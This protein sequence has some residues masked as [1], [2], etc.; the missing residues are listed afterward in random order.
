MSEVSIHTL[1]QALDINYEEE[2]INIRAEIV[3]MQIAFYRSEK[4]FVMLD[5][6]IRPIGFRT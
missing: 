2:M 1:E 4:S 5:L 6:W 3:D